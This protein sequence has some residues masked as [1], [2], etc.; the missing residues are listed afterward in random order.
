MKIE[1]YLDYRTQL[2]IDSSDDEAFFQKSLLL[3]EILPLM[4]DAKLIDSE[5]FN[6]VYFFSKER[7]IEIKSTKLKIF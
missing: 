3:S 5:D 7:N 2:L 4:M 6:E 1:E